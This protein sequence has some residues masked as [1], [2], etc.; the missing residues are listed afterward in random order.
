LTF[1]GTKINN[2]CAFINATD[3]DAI[4]NINIWNIGTLLRTTG[5]INQNN[6]LNFIP[7]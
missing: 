2:K 7:V 6:P 4:N 5:I 3:I 1:N